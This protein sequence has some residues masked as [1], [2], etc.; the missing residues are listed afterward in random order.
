MAYS[1]RTP[2]T[3]L[4][5]IYK[6][7]VIR[8]WQAKDRDKVVELIEACLK[9]YGIAL[10]TGEG[11]ADEDALRVEEFYH[12]DDKGEFF[13]TERDGKIVAT[14]AYYK[15]HRGPD[16]VE[17]RKMYIVPEHRRDGLGRTLMGVLETAIKSR[18]Y[19]NVYVETIS[20][21]KEACKFYPSLGYKPVQ[22]SPDTPR[23]DLLL[24]KFLV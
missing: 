24:H 9:P 4:K 18:G 20:V 17:I 23:C 6:E 22:D 11:G 12:K 5:S 21:L 13:V 14:A 19:R 16:S 7:Y 15:I 3:G 2:S 8:A 1:D 10:D